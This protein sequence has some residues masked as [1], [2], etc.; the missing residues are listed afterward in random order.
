M[1]GGRFTLEKEKRSE[2]VLGPVWTV[3]RI[4]PLPGFDLRSV[5]LVASRYTDYAL[6]AH[7]LF[8]LPV[9]SNTRRNFIYNI[10]IVISEKSE[11]KLN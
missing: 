6:P 7:G 2:W 11:N 4:S 9:V 5:Q 1:V 8:L 10:N 3:R